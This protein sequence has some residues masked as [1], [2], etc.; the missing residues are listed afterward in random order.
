ME[1]IKYRHFRYVGENY[2]S[3]TIAL[4]QEDEGNCR[5]AYSF[6]SPGEVF[7]KRLGR[8]IAVGRM[9]N[10]YFYSGVYNRHGDLFTNA[11]KELIIGIKYNYNFVVRTSWIKKFV[12][13]KWKILSKKYNDDNVISKAIAVDIY[14][15]SEH[16]NWYF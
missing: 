15:E 2:G 7:S 4:K 9:E 8:E 11:L 5:C 1:K 14:I 13:K 16:G 12:E 10:K 6:C 3:I